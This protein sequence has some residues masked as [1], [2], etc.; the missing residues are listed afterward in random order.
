VTDDERPDL[1][2][3]PPTTDP[4]RPDYKGAP[5]DPE[6][7]PGLGCFWLQTVAF[8]ILFVL[9]PFGVIN[10]WP[11]W[12]TTA[13]LIMTLVLLLFVGQT[14]IFLLRLV[15]A[16]RRA[17]R[18]PLRAGAS[19]TVGDLATQAPGAPDAAIP[20]DEPG[21][22]AAPGADDAG[23]AGGSSAPPSVRQ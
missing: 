23:D 18:R 4:P 16:D 15:S 13:M 5:L 10:G 7:G 6:R 12:L 8:L 19:P 3:A 14:V 2:G 21:S 9:T 1:P 20:N 17:R 11:A 22:P